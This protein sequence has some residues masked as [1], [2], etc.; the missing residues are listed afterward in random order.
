MTYFRP[1]FTGNRKREAEGGIRD[2]GD[3]NARATSARFFIAAVRGFLKE[4]SEYPKPNTH[5][6]PPTS[7][8]SIS[9]ASD[10]RTSRI[11][12][13]SSSARLRIVSAFPCA[14]SLGTCTAGI[15]ELRR[16][17]FSN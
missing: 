1:P 2:T 10:V 16:A 13:T 12:R 7:T 4:V 3:L 15:C 5:K 17:L 14:A 11:I 6:L 8:P 9:I